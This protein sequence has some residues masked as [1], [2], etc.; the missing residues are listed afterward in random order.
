MASFIRQKLESG[1]YGSNSEIIREALPGLMKQ[2]RRLEWLEGAIAL[3]WPTPRRGGCR[4]SRRCGGS[5][6]TQPLRGLLPHEGGDY[7]GGYNPTRAV[8]FSEEL[9]DHCQALADTPRAYPLVQRYEGFGIRRCVHGDYLI[10]YRLQLE[11]I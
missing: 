1:L 10:F 3:A 7:G 9:L 8:S 4:R 11:Q 5:C 6:A 2:E